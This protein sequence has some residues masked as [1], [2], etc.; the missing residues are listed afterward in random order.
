MPR[1]ATSGARRQA[2]HALDPRLARAREAAATMSVPRDGWIRTL[3]TALGMSAGNLAAR[4]GT[5]ESTVLRMETS[6][7]RAAIRLDTL[8][9]AAEALDCDLVYALVPRRG[10]AETVQA[11]A[12]RRAAMSLA[13][14][15]HTMELEAQTVPASLTED[16][17]R[18]EVE[19]WQRRPGLWDE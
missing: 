14:V 6:E 11:Q 7:T 8:R 2:R 15:Q 13:P 4:M 12:E 17:F 10:L 18:Q 9:R 5:A 19:A 16:L 3:R 1:I